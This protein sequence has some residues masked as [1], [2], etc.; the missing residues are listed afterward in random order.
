M[1]L[2]AIFKQINIGNLYQKY[3][4]DLYDLIYFSPD[5]IFDIVCDYILQ[6]TN[7]DSY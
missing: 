5:D 4:D 1:K 2:D 7:A 6:D 3:W